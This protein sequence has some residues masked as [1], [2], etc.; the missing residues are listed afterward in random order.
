[1]LKHNFCLKITQQMKKQ[2]KTDKVS[3]KVNIKFR[4]LFQ[5]N[6]YEEKKPNLFTLEIDFFH[7]KASGKAY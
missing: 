7:I 2:E 6:Y 3:L 5:R 1:M 4:H